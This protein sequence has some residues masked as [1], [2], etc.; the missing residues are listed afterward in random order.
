MNKQKT[1]E[2]R[3]EIID[4]CINRLFFSD[5]ESKKLKDQKR[6]ENKYQ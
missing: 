2:I 5:K 6:N 3:K 1:N 4:K